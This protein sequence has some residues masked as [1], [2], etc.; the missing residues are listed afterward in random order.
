MNAPLEWTLAALL[1]A[2]P[3]LAQHD[4]HMQHGHHS[5]YATQEASGISSLSRQEHDD[6]L[7]GAGMGFARPAELN[8]YPGPKHVLELAEMLE[9]SPAQQQATATVFDDM[10]NAAREL[11]ARIVDLE[12]QLDG[13]FADGTIDEGG[14][15]SVLDQIAAYRGRLRGAHLSAHLAMMNILDPSQVERYAAARG[16]SGGHDPASMHK[17]DPAHSSHSGHSNHQ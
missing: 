7:S 13:L 8:H 11:G 6:L 15:V 5:P 9:L 14:L 1:L 12:R 2:A 4:Q 10:A 17:P 16:Y 3:A